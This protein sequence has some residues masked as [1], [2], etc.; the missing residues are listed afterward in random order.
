[1]LDIVVGTQYGDEGKGRV[2]HNLALADHY[3]AAARAQGGN[4][5]G[6]T[7]VHDGVTYKLHLLPTSVLVGKPGFLGRG[8]VLD[9]DV[10]AREISALEK[11]IINPE[12]MIDPRAHVI[13]PWHKDLD[14][15]NEHGNGVYA[16]GSTGR[17]IGPVYGSK[18]D[19]TGVRLVDLLGDFARVESLVV[20]YADRVAHLTGQDISSLT[21]RYSEEVFRLADSAKIFVPFLTD[22][23]QAIH[24][25]LRLGKHILGECA[26]SDML[27]V[28]SPYYPRG[29]SSGTSATAF[30]NGIG[31]Y[32]K[33]E[34]SG[35]VI[36]VAKVYTTRVG[37]GPFVTEIDGDLA[38]Q[39]REKGGE[40]GTTTARPRRIGWLDISLIRESLVSSGLDSLA[41][42]KLDILGGMDHI[43]V[44]TH[45]T[46]VDRV[47]CFGYESVQVKYDLLKGWP[48][49][50]EEEYRNQLD[51]G[52]DFIPNKVLRDYLQLIQRKVGVPISML[53]FGQDSKAFVSYL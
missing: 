47:P 32:P 27:D 6:H 1:M 5:A 50:T 8:M 21:C 41:I 9:V 14:G 23:S 43:P 12:L 24:D 20:P 37:N 10:L 13:M 18:H 30:W 19:R 53:T 22:V 15:I 33:K 4:N 29:T 26:Q 42:T 16:A 44:A 3:M 35:K 46:P 39:I 49:F 40:F 25:Y 36:G 45:Y 31:V 17:G 34:F 52:I 38:V 2:V 28:D 51:A 48:P 7:V 11:R